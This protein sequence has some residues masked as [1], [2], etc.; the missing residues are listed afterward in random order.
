MFD[1]VLSNPTAKLGTKFLHCV[2]N[3]G[4]RR[5]SDPYLVQMRENTRKIIAVNGVT[6]MVILFWITLISSKYFA[7]YL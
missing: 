3:V 7:K 6:G 4:I 1:R 2:K 5:F